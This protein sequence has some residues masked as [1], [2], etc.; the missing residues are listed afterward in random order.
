ML[1]TATR[2]EEVQGNR[3]RIIVIAAYLLAVSLFTVPAQADEVALAEGAPGVYLVNEGDT[4]WGIANVF[5]RDPWR[6]Q[7]LW[8]INPQLDNPHLIFP[9][10]QLYLVYVDG[11]PR[12][13]VRRGQ[14][15]R[16]VKLTPKMR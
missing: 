6:W 12:L 13:R 14:E 11:Q 5:L 1:P 7:D 3:M 9:G 2:P 10:D 15:S 16:T 4:L 8:E